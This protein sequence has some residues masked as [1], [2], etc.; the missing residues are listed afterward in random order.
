MAMAGG[1]I[2]R[3]VE[4]VLLADLLVHTR[5]RTRCEGEEASKSLGIGGVEQVSTR[6]HVAVSTQPSLLGAHTQIM[7]GRH[8]SRYDLFYHRYNR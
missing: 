7:S 3:V 6:G 4:F 8:R 1:C 2:R 5:R